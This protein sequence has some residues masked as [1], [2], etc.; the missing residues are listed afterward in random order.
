MANIETISA[1]VLR[2]IIAR[3]EAT[4]Y[5][6]D[7][8]ALAEIVRLARAM[9]RAEREYN[10]VYG[11][12][13]IAEALNAYMRYAAAYDALAAALDAVDGEGIDNGGD[14]VYNENS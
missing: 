13:N 6:S 9:R 11:N 5:I 8:G 1:N 14:C 12:C 2:D 7:V 4:R 10:A 3:G